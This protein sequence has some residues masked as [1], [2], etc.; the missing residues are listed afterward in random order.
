MITRK[1]YMEQYSLEDGT[2]LFQEYYGQFVNDS[3]KKLV[4]TTFTKEKLS[5]ALKTDLHLNNVPLAKWER[6]AGLSGRQTINSWNDSGGQ[7]ALKRLI[8]GKL[9]KETGEGWSLS[10]AVC[11][12]KEAARR[13]VTE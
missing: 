7:S 4:E 5:S 9:L 12:A 2:N 13:L 11:I 6:L 8:D 1:Q 10:T 3:I